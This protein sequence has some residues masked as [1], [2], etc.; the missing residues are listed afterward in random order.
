MSKRAPTVRDYRP[1]GGQDENIIS[2]LKE[3]GFKR[4]A[5]EHDGNL[6]ETDGPW[7]RETETRKRWHWGKKVWKDLETQTL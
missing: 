1:E 7:L 2:D 5:G 3:R 6:E 4:C